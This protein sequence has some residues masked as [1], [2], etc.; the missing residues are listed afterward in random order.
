MLAEWT[1]FEEWRICLLSWDRNPT[2]PHLPPILKA[3][4]WA[5]AGRSEPNFDRWL[6][7]ERL[8]SRGRGR[9]EH[10]RDRT[11]I[12]RVSAIPHAHVGAGSNSGWSPPHARTCSP[13]AAP[14][15]RASERAT[16][17]VTISRSVS[18]DG[19][20][21]QVLRTL[22][23]GHRIHEPSWSLAPSGPGS[24]SAVRVLRRVRGGRLHPRLHSLCR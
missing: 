3:V 23:C 9:S 16:V 14:R 24:P 11:V 6:S 13:R 17:P 20:D 7:S 18:T 19:L 1:S 10:R 2:T 4:R 15:I 5:S 22:S 8:R 21:Q 12:D